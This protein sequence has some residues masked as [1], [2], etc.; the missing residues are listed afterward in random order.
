M[1]PPS[2]PNDSAEPAEPKRVEAL[3]CALTEV[4]A[5]VD[6]RFETHNL[7]AMATH[8]NGVGFGSKIEALLVFKKKG[9]A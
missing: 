1:T 5:A 8:T 3:V 9:K 7:V 6:A 2:D 4:E